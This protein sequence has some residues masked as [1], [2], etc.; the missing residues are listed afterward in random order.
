[1]AI[2][3]H[4][5]MSLA[6][7]ELNKLEAVI[8]LMMLAAY[9]DGHVSDVEREAL[10]AQIVEGTKGQVRHETVIEIVDAVERGL[11]H[12]TR[13]ERLGSIKRRLTDPRMRRAALVH[14]AKILFADARLRVDEVAFMLRAA[15]ALEVDPEE[16]TTI[17]RETRG[18]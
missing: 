1:M 10:R 13:E 16:A 14:V 7:L 6:S 15:T 12:E 18:A 9:A 3:T 2:E 11:A 17:L 5:E 4:T 8:E